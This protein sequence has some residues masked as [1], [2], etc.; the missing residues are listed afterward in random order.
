MA[1]ISLLK[2]SHTILHLCCTEGVST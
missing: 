2:I 1:V